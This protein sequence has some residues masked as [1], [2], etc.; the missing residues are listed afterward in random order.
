MGDLYNLSNTSNL[1]HTFQP[2][3]EEN[4]V[5]I[6]YQDS[7]VILDQ[8]NLNITHQEQLT[9]EILST[10][11]LEEK[12]KSNAVILM[13]LIKSCLRKDGEVLQ[14]FEKFVYP[15]FIEEFKQYDNGR[16]NPFEVMKYF[17]ESTFSIFFAKL[18][19]NP[20]QETLNTKEN[21]SS[22]TEFLISRTNP[23]ELRNDCL[24]VLRTLSD[25]SFREP[26]YD[27]Y[28]VNQEFLTRKAKFY[29]WISRKI[30]QDQAIEQ[31]PEFAEHL[32]T[33]VKSFDFDKVEIE[34]SD[35]YK[36]AAEIKK[37]GVEFGETLSLKEGEEIIT[38]YY[39]KAF[40]GYPI[41]NQENNWESLFLTDFIFDDNNRFPP[42]YYSLPKLREPFAYKIL[43][44]F[45]MGP[46][47]EF[48]INPYISRGFYIAKQDLTHGDQAFFELGKDVLHNTHDFD[49]YLFCAHH[50]F[51]KQK[52]ESFNIDTTVLDI[53]I[54]IMNLY[55]INKGNIGFLLKGYGEDGWAHLWDNNIGIIPQI[56]DFVVPTI[57][58]ESDRDLKERFL[59]GDLYID[60]GE[61][62]ILQKVLQCESKEDKYYLGFKA[63]QRIQERLKNLIPVE[64]PDCD[65]DA[66]EFRLKV[67]LKQKADE[68][69]TLLLQRRNDLPIL[70]N[71]TNAE[72]IG[73]KFK[74]S[75]DEKSNE[76]KHITTIEDL[77]V[78][79]D[80]YCKEIIH[81]YHT[82]K[83]IIIK[84]YH[85]Y[86]D[87]E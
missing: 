1:S 46:H 24:T 68:L 69:K 79:L 3:L 33:G 23:E 12:P 41:E 22:K 76:K 31:I 36:A 65:Q 71:R 59:E 25:F 9:S 5:N 67:L 39:I 30:L 38:R 64:N 77:F 6:N 29:F 52:Q 75:S 81:I 87:E 4:K 74:S 72:L 82:L 47:V 66:D 58:D 17:M 50:R 56:V 85:K 80:K 70:R 14:F 13:D 32:R 8:M 15:R 37:H 19:G 28:G 48:V 16:L 84:G 61:Y 21:F 27:D 54:R 20:E 40:F 43:E 2:R 55:D 78:N 34:F 49:F 10:N 35:Q 51:E 73:F 60:Y 7:S 11:D 83:N 18:I 63:I 62:S 44:C 53:M 45:G 57:N 86:Y 26:V 42:A